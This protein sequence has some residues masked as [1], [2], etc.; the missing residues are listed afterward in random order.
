MLRKKELLERDRFYHLLSEQCNSIDPATV[1]LIYFGLVGLIA[2]ELRK[3]KFIRLPMLADIALVHQK[4]RPAW[5]GKRHVIIDGRETLK[6]YPKER[7][8]RYWNKRQEIHVLDHM[9]PAAIS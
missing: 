1:V 8:R 2:N 9:P 6:V 7:F 4:A 3:H 5:V